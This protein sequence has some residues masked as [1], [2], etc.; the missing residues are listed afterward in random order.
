MEDA[1]ESTAV[2]NPDSSVGVS[3]EPVESYTVKVDGSEEQVSLEE[4]RDGYQR[5]SDYTRKTQ[6]LASER[7]RL[8]QAEAIVTSLEADPE[9]TMTALADAFGVSTNQA[10]KTTEVDPYSAAWGDDTPDP[11]EDRI[12]GLEQKLAAQDR[13]HRR[14]QVEKQVEDL[15]GQYGDFDAHDL[16]QHALA[17]KISN[18]EAALTHMRYDDVSR[19]AQKLEQEQERTEAKRDASVVTP[20]GSKQA[21]SS[22]A[23]PEK[24]SSIREAFENAKRELAS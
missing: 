14:Q 7:K 22:S 5:Q 6:E 2:D 15:K 8:Q 19:R 21:G 23:A 9:G 16:F 10:S 18:L 24:V 13:V 1:M 11:T 4:L 17:N 3:Q 12:R 20:S